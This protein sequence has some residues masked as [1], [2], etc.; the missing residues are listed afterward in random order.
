MSKAFTSEE[1]D[2]APIAGRAVERAARG[3]LRPI[4]PEGYA[5]LQQQLSQLVEQGA[6]KPD[7]D[8][9]LKHRAALLEATLESVSSVERVVDGTARLGSV[10]AVDEAGAGRRVYTLVGPD[11]V[12]VRAGRVSALSPLGAALLGKRAGDEVEVERPK[13]TVLLA[14]LHVD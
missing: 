6:L 5:R 1:N 7:A 11:E 10:V 9:S 4:T 13:G 2:E 8:A 14:V 12:D 3:A